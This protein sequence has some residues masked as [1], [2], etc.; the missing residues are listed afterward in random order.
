MVVAGTFPG[1]PEA[2]RIRAVFLLAQFPDLS[3]DSPRTVFTDPIERSG[4]VERLADYYAEVSAGR[5]TIESTVAQSIV[6]VPKPRAAYVQKPSVMVRDAFVGFFELGDEEASRT[7][8]ET[9]DAVIVF[10]AGPGKESDLHGSANDPWSNFTMMTPPLETPRGRQIRLGCVIAANEREA[11][12]SFGV[13]CHEFGHLLGL[14]ELY[15]PYGASH[16][17]IGVWGLMGQ[18]TW[19][20]RGDRPP[21]PSAWCKLAMGWADASLVTES[22]RV[23]L[24]AADITTQVVKIW[25]KGPEHPK[26]YFLVENRRREETDRGLPGAGLLIWHV[27]ER[28]TGYRTSQSNPDRMRI[29]L[30]QADGR[31]DLRVGHRQGGNRGDATDPWRGLDRHWQ[32]AL[33]GAIVLGVLCVVAGLVRCRR[34]GVDWL[35]VATLACGLTGA[36]VGFG[37]SRSP[38]F[39][40]DTRPSSGSWDGDRGRFTISRISPPG[41]PMS[42]TVTFHATEEREPV[43]RAVH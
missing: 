5:F 3:L 30:M 38:V 2:G 13:L 20:G 25:A 6:T 31:D 29:T 21:H 35:S 4:L 7:A 41:D 28:V 27:D 11:L 32:L 10:F 37:V 23:T 40:A 33:D 24:P 9:A 1:A 19:L 34:R 15:A 42:F 18:G 14:P 43:A 26:E 8:L 22:G 17:G 39:G 16:E 36:V 12:S